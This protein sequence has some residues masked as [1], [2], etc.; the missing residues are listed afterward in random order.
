MGQRYFVESVEVASE[1]VYV[2]GPLGDIVDGYQRFESLW[3]CDSALLVQVSLGKGVFEVLG[4][5]L[6]K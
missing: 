2:E 6:V 4:L 1:F 3:R 5:S